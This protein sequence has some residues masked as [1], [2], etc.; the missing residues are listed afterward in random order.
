MPAS[1]EL[2]A[3]QGVLHPLSPFLG[4]TCPD[5]ALTTLLFFI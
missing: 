5:K 4:K 3:P 2:K 1:F